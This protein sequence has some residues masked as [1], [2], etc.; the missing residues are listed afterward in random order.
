SAPACVRGAVRAREPARC[1]QDP[2]SP[3][4]HRRR[5]RSAIMPR[6]V[7]NPPNP[8]SSEHVEWIGPPP[9]AKLEVFEEQAKSIVA[10]ND[11]PDIPLPGSV[12]PDRG[13]HPGCA[14]CYARPRH[15]LLGWGAGT[16]VERK[17]VDKQNAAA[18]LRARFESPS[19]PG[20]PLNFSGVT[21]CY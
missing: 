2:G 13:C 11:S 16:D 10:R 19:W 12:N 3:V 4:R 18:L 20:E 9:D 5:A 15:E 8:W 14:Y 17:I 6:P 1:R 21:D 7:A